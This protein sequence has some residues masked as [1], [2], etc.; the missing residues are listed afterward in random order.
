MPVA[1][2]EAMR[3]RADSSGTASGLL[4]LV[5]FAL[6]GVIGPVVGAFGSGSA[7]PLGIGMS[8]CLLAA[9]A[10]CLHPAPRRA[11]AFPTGTASDRS[12]NKA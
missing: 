5:Q 9:F 4:G 8:A 6:G 3:A 1:S 2:A 11:A 12:Q 7:L 10:L